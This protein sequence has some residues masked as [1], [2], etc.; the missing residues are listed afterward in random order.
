MALGQRHEN[1]LPLRDWDHP[2]AAHLGFPKI[3][4]LLQRHLEMVVAAVLQKIGRSGH[5]LAVVGHPR[6]K[7]RP[8][9]HL[10]QRPLAIQ[11][12]EPLVEREPAA[13]VLVRRQD[14]RV[15]KQSVFLRYLRRLKRNQFPLH[16]GLRLLEPLL[17]DQDRVT[18]LRLHA[19]RAHAVERQRLAFRVELSLERRQQRIVPKHG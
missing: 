7:R 15:E 19:D 4:L 14:G 2:P 9:A 12:L 1:R 3:D 11:R 8:V 10:F 13:R 17:A 16:L 6:L 5:R 18:S